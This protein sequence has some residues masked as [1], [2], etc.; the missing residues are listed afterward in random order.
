ML[1]STTD[2]VKSPYLTTN[3]DR[4]LNEQLGADRKSNEQVGAVRAFQ[5]VERMVLNKEGMI[6]I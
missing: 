5:F 1:R 3:K 4:K 6:R 2:P